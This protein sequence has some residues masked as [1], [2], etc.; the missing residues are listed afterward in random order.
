M[1][2]CSH[3]ITQD[4]A[5][6]WADLLGWSPTPWLLAG[7]GL[8]RAWKSSLGAEQEGAKCMLHGR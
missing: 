2:R 5:F 3:L 6:T 1:K 7:R 4:T 8:Q